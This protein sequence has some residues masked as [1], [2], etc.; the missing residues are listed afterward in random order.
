MEPRLAEP[1]RGPPLWQAMEL[2]TG[3]QSYWGFE[4]RLSS[5]YYSLVHTVYICIINYN[6]IGLLFNFVLYVCFY[7]L[8]EHDGSV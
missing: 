7:I 5:T 6:K 2:V 4:R 1:M 8:L 3:Q